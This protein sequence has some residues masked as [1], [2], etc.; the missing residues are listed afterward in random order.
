[1]ANELPNLDLRPTP[2]ASLAGASTSG[3]SGGGRPRIGWRDVWAKAKRVFVW[4]FALTIVFLVSAWISLPTRAIAWRIAHEARA[5]GFNLTI[6]DVS[7]RPWGSATLHQVVWNFEP[8]R[9]DSTPVPFVVTELDVDFGVLGYLLFDEIDVE[10]EGT[11]DQG[12]VRGAYFKGEDEARFSL[13]IEELPLYGVPKLQDAVNAPVRGLFA[14][15]VELTMPGGKWSEADGRMEIHCASCTIGDD[16]TKLF[17]PG[18]KKTS[19][20]AKGISIPE[21]DL[22]TLDGV[23][24][25]NDGQAVAEEFGNE[26]DDIRIKIGGDITFK[27]PVGKSQLNL[28]IKVFV[29]PGLRSRSDELDLMVA[30]AKDTVKMDPPDEGWLAFYLEGTFKN[31]K[32]RGIK[33]KT[34][35]EAL[36]EKREKREKAKKD[37]EAKKAKAK[38]DR[39]AAKAAAEAAKAEASGGE[40]EGGDTTTGGE[41][42]AADPGERPTVPPEAGI[43]MMAAEPSGEAGEGGGEAPSGEAG[44]GGGEGGDEIGGEQPQPSEEVPAEPEQT[45]ESAPQ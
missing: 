31:R 24:V 1:M 13:A 19:M 10:F 12:M 39:E 32:F 22:G 41:E 14:L 15:S 44:E 35:A 7:L 36:R 37:R 29:T 43:Q 34:A 42:P 20:L 9:P 23:L 6:D 17:V 38:A 28:L 27:D 3:L 18:T 33:Q 8:S 25:V 30:T 16:E 21:I 4:V 40:A 5:K 45:P 26:S 11:L 2:D